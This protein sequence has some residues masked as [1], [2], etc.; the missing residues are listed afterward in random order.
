MQVVHLVGEHAAER[1]GHDRSTNLAHGLGA[2]WQQPLRLPPHEC[3][4]PVLHHYHSSQPR[5]ADH[6]EPH[7]RRA[8]ADRT[9][10]LV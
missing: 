5:L 1:A 9:L 7:F 8:V 6:V 2:E 4:V 10:F 3:L